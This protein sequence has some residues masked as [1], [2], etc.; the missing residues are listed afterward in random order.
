MTA[1][2]RLFAER[3]YSRCS[4]ADV[5]AAAGLSKRQ[6]YEVFQ[7]RED[8]LIAAYDRIQDEAAAAV[9]RALAALGEN[10]DPHA[11]VTA[12]F[13]AYLMSFTGDPYRPKLTLIESVGV[14]DRVEQHRRERRRMWAHLLTMAAA[15]VAGRGRRSRGTV[16][17]AAAALIGASNGVVQEWLLADPRPPLT[18]LLEVLVP[19]ALA[20]IDPAGDRTA[21]QQ[22]SDKL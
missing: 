1:A 8:V 4:L 2:I 11:A 7:T 10:P 22:H 16:Q 6:F 14:S 15:P 18:D 21:V 13:T 19:T 12:V 20:F 9:T 5:C 3:G 17:L